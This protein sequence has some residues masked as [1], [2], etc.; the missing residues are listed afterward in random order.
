[1]PVLI[2]KKLSLSYLIQNLTTEKRLAYY[3][4]ILS[5]YDPNAQWQALSSDK[6]PI[7]EQEGETLASKAD[8]IK[9][10]STSEKTIPIETL[11]SEQE[12][13]IL[14]GADK[15]A[16][17]D[18]AIVKGV[19]KSF[20]KALIKKKFKEDE[21]LKK[22]LEFQKK[23]EEAQRKKLEKASK[24]SFEEDTSL[25]KAEPVKIVDAKQHVGKRV[26]I[27]GWIQTMRTQ[28][29]Q[30][31]FLEVRDGTEIIQSMLQGS[32]CQTVDA[33]SLCRE[34]SIMLR[35]TLKLDER[36][37][38]G[39]ELQ[40]DFWELIGTAPSVWPINQDT[41][42]HERLNSAHLYARE[43]RMMDILRMRSIITQCFRE[44]FFARGYTEFHPS[45]LVQTMCE[46][47]STLFGLD[48]FGEPAYL[49]QSSQLYLETVMPS[50][51]DVFCIAQSYRAERSQTPRHL[52]EYT[53]IEAERPFITFE[54]LLET[55]EDL[56]CDVSKR[57]V[58][59]AGPVLKRVNPHFVAPQGKFKRMTYK[60]CIDFCREHNICQDPS[61]VDGKE[62]VPFEYGD[63]ITDAP[64]REMIK[65]IGEPVSMIKF[66]V[67]MKSF[68]MSRCQEDDTLTESV[69]VLLPGVGET[70]GGSMRMHDLQRLEEA[71]VR[72]GID[73]QNYYWY[74]DQRR[75]GTSPHGGYGLGLER[76]MMWI[77]G[78]PHIRDTTLY[79]RYMGRCL[80]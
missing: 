34:C 46:G 47:G 35:G 41:K 60:A 53:H 23:E 9:F 73:P 3:Q 79:P 70:I 20:I 49:T 33:L 74:L 64:E 14:I 51:G 78:I 15:E 67:E 24:I 32:L 62:G 45:T 16:D 72:E 30:L 10:F 48:F 36:A 29:S 2:Q 4:A 59:K 27:K 43:S 25:P 37:Y 11:L 65:L 56:I 40:V 75:F 54:D 42:V 8:Q 71:Y 19:A 22:Q 12:V 66:P 52:A 5:V 13:E 80:P 77:L 21:K 39:V 76:F 57:V 1:M 69:D 17:L 18:K 63:D 44:H 68:Y 55:V 58:E 38:N 50:L 6:V 7:T 31:M 26:E 61:K 28:G